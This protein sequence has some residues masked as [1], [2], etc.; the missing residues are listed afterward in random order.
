MALSEG[1]RASADGA[2]SGRRHLLDVAGFEWG[3]LRGLLDHAMGMRA[4]LATP[5]RRSD[6]LRGKIGRA[7]V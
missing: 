3:Q 7:H 2:P 1:S 4:I 5:E 6:E